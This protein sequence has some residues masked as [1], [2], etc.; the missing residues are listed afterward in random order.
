MDKSNNTAS[1]HLSAGEFAFALSAFQV[2]QEALDVVQTQLGISSDQEAQLI[3]SSSGH[4]LLARGLAS[5]NSDDCY[6][7]NPLIEEAVRIL[8]EA[9]LTIQCNR[10]IGDNLEFIAFHFSEGTI[11]K[12]YLRDQVVHVFEKQANIEYAAAAATAF[13][14]VP[15]S[16]SYDLSLVKIR[17]DLVQE[18]RNSQDQ[19]YIEDKL[20]H[21]T[22]EIRRPLT[23]DLLNSK[24]RGSVVRVD[25]LEDGNSQSEHRFFLLAGELRV[26]LVNPDRL[27]GE[28]TDFSIA[29]RD[30]FKWAFLQAIEK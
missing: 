3:I 12:H 18:I 11:V 29:S 24:F 7:L 1:L 4:S 9:N 15:E 16:V 26:W 25:H 27:T 28:T 5:I 19:E 6:E 14:E 23:E 30:N 20:A 17:Q 21:I 2:E 8:V 22:Q 13:F 10:S